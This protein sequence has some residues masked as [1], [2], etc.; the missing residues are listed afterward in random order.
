[1]YNRSQP[2]IKGAKA[3][4]NIKPLTN[5]IKF[6]VKKRKVRLGEIADS[7]TIKEAI[8]VVPYKIGL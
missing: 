3:Y 4:Q 8:V 2:T 5:V 6:K 1:M 7:K